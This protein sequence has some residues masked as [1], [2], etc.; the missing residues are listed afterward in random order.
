MNFEDLPKFVFQRTIID[1]DR[2]VHEGRLSTSVG[3]RVGRAWLWREVTDDPIEG[4]LKELREDLIAKFVAWQRFSPAAGSNWYCFDGYWEPAQVRL[5]L[6]RSLKWLRTEYRPS[7]AVRYKCGDD[8]SLNFVTTEVGR[9]Q[10]SSDCET[11]EIVPGGWHMERCVICDEKI[12]PQ[13][14]RFGYRPSEY[15]PG[16]NSI[17]P[18]VCERCYRTYVARQSLGFL[19]G[20]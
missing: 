2:S 7:D 4:E 16:P 12:G 8:Q 13:F 10:P 9:P 3:L 5:V 20:A 18:W 1:G 17:G 14:Q 19:V 6:D 11:V 15:V